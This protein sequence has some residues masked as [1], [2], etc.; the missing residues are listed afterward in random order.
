M[1]TKW[2]EAQHAKF[3]ATMA[4]RRERGAR[5][6]PHEF[7]RCGVPLSTGRPCRMPAEHP[8]TVVHR[9]RLRGEYARA[10][11][12]RMTGIDLTC[13]PRSH[14]EAPKDPGTAVD[15]AAGSLA[16]PAPPAQ[17]QAQESGVA[18]AADPT[19]SALAGMVSKLA[20]VVDA[21]RWT[22]LRIDDRVALLVGAA[23]LRPV[24]EP[25]A[26]SRDPELV[27]AFRTLHQRV[28]ELERHNVTAGD[29][30]EQLE[31]VL[32]LARSMNHRLGRL[33]GP[34]PRPRKK[35]T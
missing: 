6:Y 20:E 22:V 33:A 3:R 7:P 19:A 32:Q 35:A 34:E 1:G 25:V 31:E 16:P 24:P 26:P 30:E 10:V 18:V 21:M 13:P 14:G 11:V 4:A 8:D 29:W 12:L 28:R 23:G 9:E 15:T 2:S 5:L 17:A 27:A